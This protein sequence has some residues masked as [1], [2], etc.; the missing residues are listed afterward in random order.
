MRI[1]RRRSDSP[2]GAAVFIVVVSP[3]IGAVPAEGSP[4]PAD[5]EARRG[6]ASEAPDDR[7][8]S[9]LVADDDPVQAKGVCDF[10][11]GIGCSARYV[12]SGEAVVVAYR[13]TPADVVFLD[14]HM[15]PM[16]AADVI[17]RL[18][19]IDPEVKVIVVTSYAL[20]MPDLAAQ[21]RQAA[22][23][24]FVQ[25]EALWDSAD[26]LLELVRKHTH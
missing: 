19:E 15:P 12:T 25:K 7:P 9:A 26:D 8:L 23:L 13:D 2:D 14:M 20:A 17:I 10:L 18:A 16:N 22:P 5:D 21:S 1:I 4:A 3:T 11:N 6:Q 24:A